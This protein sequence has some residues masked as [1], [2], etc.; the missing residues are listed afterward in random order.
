MSNLTPI[1]TLSQSADTTV[2]WMMHRLIS[3]GYQVERTFDLHAARMSQADCPCPLHGTTDCSCQMVVFLVHGQEAQPGTIIVHGYDDETCIS[4]LDMASQLNQE[5]II[6]AL[7]PVT[8]N[9][10][11]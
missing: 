2:A 4:L 8:E 9:S 3:R 5:R 10:G 7:L 6:Q 1:L 11:I